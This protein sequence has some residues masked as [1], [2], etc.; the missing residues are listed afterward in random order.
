MRA[1]LPNLPNP[2]GYR[3]VY[4]YIYI[5]IHKEFFVG[6]SKAKTVL[7]RAATHDVT[8]IMNSMGFLWKESI[9]VVVCL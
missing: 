2:P 6:G 7:Y 8:N 5:H 3:P 4:I 9:I 1:V